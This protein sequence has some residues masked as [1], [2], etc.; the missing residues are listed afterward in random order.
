MDNEKHGDQIPRDIRSGAP[1]KPWAIILGGSRGL[2]LAT[3]RKLA[4][5]GYALIVIHRDRKADMGEIGTAFSEM[6]AQ[7]RAF[8]SF[9][10]DAT[11]TERRSD[12]ITEIK[13]RLAPDEKIRVLVHSIAKGNLK[14]MYDKKGNSLGRQDFQI[15]MDAMAMSLFDWT[16]ALLEANLFAQDTRILSFTSEGSSRVLPNYAA[17]ALA[18]ASLESMTRSIAVEFAPLGV[19]ANCIQAG[20]T[21]TESFSRI[22]HSDKIAEVARKRNPGGRLTLP[23]DVANVVYLLCTEEAKWITGTVIVVDG[24][25]SARL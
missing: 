13:S 14:P 11:S 8:L 4:S 10:A 12:L 22:P 23:E 9:N 5:H 2:G 20:V 19:K 7:S 17:V 1:Q 6:A 18:K 24:G 3:G 15:T 16:K 25:E 21:I